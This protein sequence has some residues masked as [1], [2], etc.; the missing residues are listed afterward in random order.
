[1]PLQF[2]VQV[3]RQGLRV[4]EIPTRLIYK[5]P[6]RHFGGDL[7]DPAARLQYYYDVLISELIKEPG[8]AWPVP[9]DLP[10]MWVP[11]RVSPFKF[12]Q[13]TPCD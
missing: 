11:G 1:M 4:R 10:G 12:P 6:N 8:P 7:D 2:W 3:A 9:A 13:T 5:D